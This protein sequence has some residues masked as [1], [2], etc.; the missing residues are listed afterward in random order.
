MDE[1]YKTYADPEC[2][3]YDE[4]MV[5][6]IEDWKKIADRDIPLL[7]KGQRKIFNKVKDAFYSGAQELIF[8][9]GDGGTGESRLSP[10]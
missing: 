5:A 4:D 6:E 2:P 9:N 7:N 3:D 1:L 10:T 8:V